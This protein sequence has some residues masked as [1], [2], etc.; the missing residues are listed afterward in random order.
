[1]SV[2]VMLSTAGSVTSA[3][4]IAETLVGEKLAACVTL[5]PGALSFF[6][7]EGK[8]AREKETVILAKAP[9]KNISKITRKIKQIHSYEIP[10]IL[11]FSAAGGE[12]AYLN[13]VEE[14]SGRK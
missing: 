10:E 8:I 7:W 13:W 12:K 3:R 14:S 5:L 4:K 11:F 2:W 9:R 1:M 6:F